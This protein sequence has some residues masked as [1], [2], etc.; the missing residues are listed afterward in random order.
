MKVI[1]V[2]TPSGLNNL[3]ITE[4]PDPSPN[5]GEILVRWHAT[6]LNYHDYL[7]A[8]GGIPVPDGRIPM[9][10]GAGEV[11]AIGKEVGGWIVGDKVMSMFFPDWLEGKPSPKKNK[12]HH[13]GNSRW[14]HG[15]KILF[16]SYC[17]HHNP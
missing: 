12:I 13:G 15:G 5:A 3:Q 4:R 11:V 8:V 2:K 10:D 14:L 9:S 7:V 6:S 16:T 17:C 1:Q